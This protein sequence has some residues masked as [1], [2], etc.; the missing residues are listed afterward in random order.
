MTTGENT[1]QVTIKICRGIFVQHGWVP[2]AKMETELVMALQDRVRVGGPRLGYGV[3][4][5][6]GKVMV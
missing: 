5:G 2:I 6:G 3:G 4:G 1:G